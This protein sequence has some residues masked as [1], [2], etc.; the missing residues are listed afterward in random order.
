MNVWNNYDLNRTN[1]SF[2]KQTFWKN[3]KDEK[4]KIEERI[5][6]VRQSVTSD[7]ITAAAAASV[8][9]LSSAV[10]WRP[11]ATRVSSST[12]ARSSECMFHIGLDEVS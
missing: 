9:A 8:G 2:Q 11:H 1:I 6:K 7:A 12:Y 4:S 5:G 3:L 10:F